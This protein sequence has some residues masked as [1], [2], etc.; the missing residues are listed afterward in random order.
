MNTE[1]SDL[2]SQVQQTMRENLEEVI[3]VDVNEAYITNTISTEPNIAY[4]TP[5]VHINTVPHE[6]DYIAP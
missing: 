6:Y 1:G 4:S 5:V 3:E 2:E